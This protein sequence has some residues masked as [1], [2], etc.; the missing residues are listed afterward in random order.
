MHCCNIKTS[1]NVLVPVWTCHDQPITAVPM[2]NAI[3]TRQ[4]PIAV[5]S[6]CCHLC[7][8]TDAHCQNYV[9]HTAFF[10]YLRYEPN[11]VFILDNILWKPA[12]L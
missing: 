6:Y 1:S 3:R 5:R 10:T 7:I 8:A 11:T 12:S 4:T 2:E 9:G